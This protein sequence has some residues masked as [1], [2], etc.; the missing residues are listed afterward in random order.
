M[1]GYEYVNLD[2]RGLQ[3]IPIYLY[4][5]AHQ[6]VC[7]NLSKNPRL[8]L[9][10]DFIQACSAL[11]ELRMTDM[12]LKRI[13]QSVRQAT[14]LTRLDVSNNRI[15]ELDHVVLE[16]L[17]ELIHL[18]A[19]NNRLFQLPAYFG[20]FHALKYLII[21]NNKFESLPLAVCEITS[22]IDLDVS[23][24]MLSTLPDGISQL[25][26]LERLV[27]FGNAITSLPATFGGL[28]GLRELDARRNA[29]S[30]FAVLAQLPK[31]EV[32]RLQYNAAPGL[33]ARLP[34]VRTINASHNPLTTLSLSDMAAT[35]TSLNL[36]NAKLTSLP[37][38]LFAA[39]L[40]ALE[41]LVVDGNQL[42]TLPDA[43]GSC[44]RL[45]RLSCRANHI[46]GVPASIGKLQRLRELD[47]SN[48]DVHSL[49]AEI[50]LCGELVS[51]NASSNLLT[52][53][54]DPPQLA[55]ED[56]GGEDAERKA[57]VASR[58]SAQ[59][60]A[61]A[62]AS[63]L[64]RLYLADNRL[65]DET[66][67]P[68]SLMTELRILNLSFNELYEIPSRVLAKSAL[69]EELY[70]SGNMLTTLPEDDMARLSNLRALHLNGNKLQT[71]PAE[72]G[73]L[74][75]LQYLDVG[76]NQLKY[77]IANWKFDWNWCVPL[78]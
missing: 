1:D 72:L 43:I 78:S 51:L 22:L 35:L 56:A 62:A 12:A 4:R 52:E 20:R 60:V 28:V 53:F 25:V 39:T 50:W 71:L 63:S 61:A 18:K 6:L 59:R 54:P 11:R 33:E 67:H 5:H 9:P 15:V 48:N 31:L 37:A 58:S 55:V 49:A 23:F 30:S 26:N 57:S 75:R 73:Q 29:I 21:S 77:N 8:E 65:P 44:T 3:T 40:I 66:F 16:D 24:N 19:S 34:C 36:T 38:E 2:A 17:S 10:S 69:L 68:I 32:A 47:V 46:D 70:L 27:L 7:L 74:K 42:R 64:Q 41:V 13:P 45:E 14:G 76:N